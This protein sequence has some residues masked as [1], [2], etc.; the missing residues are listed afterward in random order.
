[1]T[2]QG[3]M[4]RHAD[5]EQCFFAD[6]DCFSLHAASR[7]GADDR[8]VL[9]QLCQYINSLAHANERVQTNAVGQIALRLKTALCDGATH[10]VMLPLEFMQRMA[11]LIEPAA[12]APAKINR[13]HLPPLI[14]E[15]R[16]E[17]AGS[18]AGGQ[19]RALR[20]DVRQGLASGSS[21]PWDTEAL[22]SKARARQ[23]NGPARV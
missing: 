16:T 9:A 1:M 10:L 14:P 4:P 7:G 3:A 13:R 21:Q 23:T 5:L 11:V 6:I 20:S 19:A 17:R 15:L 2:V 8:E 18:I 22:K 12:P